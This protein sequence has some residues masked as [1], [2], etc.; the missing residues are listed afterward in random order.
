MKLDMVNISLNVQQ[1][2]ILFLFYHSTKQCLSLETIARSIQNSLSF[3]L[4]QGAFGKVYKAEYLG[5]EVWHSFFFVFNVDSHK[6][7]FWFW[8]LLSRKSKW[9]KSQT[10]WSS[11]FWN[12]KLHC[13]STRSRVFDPFQSCQQTHF[14]VFRSAR[15]PNIVTFLGSQTILISFQFISFLLL[16]LFFFLTSF[17]LLLGHAI[18]N[19]GQPNEEVLL[20][21]EYL[22]R[23]D[24]RSYLLSHKNSLTWMTKATNNKMTKQKK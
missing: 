23:G 7:K 4:S 14:L 6:T 8:R 21:M 2:S 3:F 9:P 13:S 19:K 11:C 10:R 17:S 20:V 24:L 5:A 18:V 1:N 15:H 12:V 16:L 22:S